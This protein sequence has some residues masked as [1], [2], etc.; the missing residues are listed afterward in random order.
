MQY[1]RSLRHAPWAGVLH[2]WHL[3]TVFGSSCVQSGLVHASACGNLNLKMGAGLRDLGEV[4]ER[5]L[6][7]VKTAEGKGSVGCAAL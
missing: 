5:G 6:D 2:L 4:F 1:N 3:F 7:M